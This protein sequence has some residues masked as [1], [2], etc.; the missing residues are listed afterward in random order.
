MSDK[1]ADYREADAP[2][3][4]RNRL[5][6]L[7]GAGFERLGDNGALIERPLPSYGPQASVFRISR[8]FA[9]DKIIHASIAT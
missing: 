9:P 2:L 1:L 4:E 5:W 3:P 8:S 7:Y 6:P